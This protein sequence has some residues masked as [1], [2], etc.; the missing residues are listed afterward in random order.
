MAG[1]LIFESGDRPEIVQKQ[2]VSSH[3]SN[4]LYLYVVYCPSLLG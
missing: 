3:E 4:W 1:A 2:I